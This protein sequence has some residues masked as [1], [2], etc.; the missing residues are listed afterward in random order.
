MAADL[1]RVLVVDDDA[2]TRRLLS[3]VLRAKA[4]HVDEASDGAEALDLLALHAYSVI[5]LDILM[6][7]LNGLDVLHGIGNGGMFPVVLVVSGA[8]PEVLAE[9]D[10][11]RI[12]GVVRKPFEPDEIAALVSSCVDIQNRRRL[13]A[14]IAAGMLVSSPLFFVVS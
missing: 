4:L 11:R 13:E 8:A 14:M 12:H 1:K 9:L 2:E 10:P 6:P 7:R 5:L 3:T